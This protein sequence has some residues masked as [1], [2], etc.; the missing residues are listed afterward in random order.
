M[1]IQLAQGNSI[2]STKLRDLND[3][4]LIELLKAESS[5]FDAPEW[6]IQRALA[7]WAPKKTAVREPGVIAKIMAVLTFDSA[8]GSNLAFGVRAGFPNS[9]QMLFSAE[10]RDIDLR[11]TPV[12][13]DSG[14]AW[15][16]VG[17][18]FGPDIEGTA[19]LQSQHNQWHAPLNDLNEFRLSTVPGGTY[20]MTLALTETSIVLPEFQV[21][22]RRD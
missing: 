5:Q 15:D 20:T 19:L 18:V 4:A 17:Q 3:E 12:H 10:G 9:R 11:V 14:P 8:V 7:V 16:I 13:S 6:A 21:P 2:V 1:E 22:L